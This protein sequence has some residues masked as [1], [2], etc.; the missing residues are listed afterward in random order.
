MKI[1][2]KVIAEPMSSPTRSSLDTL[3]CWTKYRYVSRSHGRY[4]SCVSSRSWSLKGSYSRWRWYLKQMPNLCH[5][6]LITVQIGYL[7][8]IGI[9]EMIC[10]SPVSQMVSIIYLYNHWTESINEDQTIAITENMLI[11]KTQKWRW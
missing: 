5:Y 8:R 7:D 1:I 11:K 9:I 2:L 6:L 4:D 3:S 10:P